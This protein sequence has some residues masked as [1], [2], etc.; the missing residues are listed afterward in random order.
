MSRA[1][2]VH[3]LLYKGQMSRQGVNC[4]LYKGQ[5]SR[6]KGV[7]CLLYKGLQGCTQGRDVEV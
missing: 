1:K 4:L 7:A 3:C 2:G 5:M 6:S